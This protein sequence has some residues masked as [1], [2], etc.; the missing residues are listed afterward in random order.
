MEVPTITSRQQ[1]L[2]GWQCPVCFKVNAP[3]IQECTCKT[4]KRTESTGDYAHAKRI[5]AM[6]F[7]ET[8][9]TKKKP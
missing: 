1:A 2:Q 7:E 5:F 4:I 6:I 8:P 9:Q 3:F